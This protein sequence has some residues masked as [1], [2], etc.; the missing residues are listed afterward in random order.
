MFNALQTFLEKL[1]ANCQPSGT[2]S[3]SVENF[4]SKKAAIDLLYNKTETG[5]KRASMHKKYI[6]EKLVEQT[7]GV[8]V[9]MMDG[10][11]RYKDKG[12]YDRVACSKEYLW[13][14]NGASLIDH[15]REVLD[16]GREKLFILADYQLSK[17]VMNELES[18]INL[19]E[20][21]LYVPVVA[22]G[23]IKAVHSSLDTL[24]AEVHHIL[25]HELDLLMVS[26]EKTHP[27]FFNEYLDVCRVVEYH[28]SNEKERRDSFSDIAA[29]SFE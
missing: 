25:T 5:N 22:T 29:V 2:F 14:L 13:Q 9:M 27:D 26:F 4:K 8:T 1:T 28:I 20:Q 21:M 16:L 11:T 17:A 6:G 24:F 10:F 15:A 18:T 3:V 7:Y 19:Y 12:L 23:E